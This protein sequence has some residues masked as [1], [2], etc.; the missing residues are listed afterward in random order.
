MYDRDAIANLGSTVQLDGSQFGVVQ[1]LDR[2]KVNIRA[3]HSLR[4]IRKTH[5]QLISQTILIKLGRNRAESELTCISL[6]SKMIL[7]AEVL[8]NLLVFLIKG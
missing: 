6:D 2:S 8:G 5:N 1:L 3:G 7:G 4:A